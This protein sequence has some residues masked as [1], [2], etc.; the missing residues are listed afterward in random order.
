MSNNERKRRSTWS[1]AAVVLLSGCVLDW[2]TPKGETEA[3]DD[4]GDDTTPTE[5]A[6]GVVDIEDT[7]DGGPI[8]DDA[9]EHQQEADAEDAE[10]E[11]DAEADGDVLPP[12]STEWCTE[13]CGWSG[14]RVG[15][16]PGSGM[17]C[18]CTEPTY[19]GGP[20]V[21]FAT[22]PLW[23]VY[24]L[25]VAAGAVCT[26]STCAEFTGDTYIIISGG[27]NGE[28]DNACGLGSEITTDAIP[29]ENPLSVYIK[30]MSAEC[31]WSITVDCTPDCLNGDGED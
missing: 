13:F 9:A 29:I 25:H 8:E 20:F 1:V 16:C 26:I 15:T 5:S 11:G 27:W 21:G 14:F 18:Y 17:A 4:A 19:C 12:C 7:D 28:N 30:C 3:D 6:D 10:A 22:S 31:S 2:S 24:T 23:T